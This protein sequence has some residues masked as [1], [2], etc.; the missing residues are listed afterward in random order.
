MIEINHV[1]LFQTNITEIYI[2]PS[3]YD[4]E[5]IVKTIYENYK[6]NSH[7]NNWDDNSDLHQY[8]RDWNNPNFLQINFDSLKKVYN[9]TF[10]S[11]IESISFNQDSIFK[12]RWEIAN[13]TV[14]RQEQYM[15]VHDHLADSCVFSVVHYISFSDSHTLINFKN[16]LLA[17]QYTHP[18]IEDY[19]N[20]LKNDEVQNSTYFKEWDVKPKEDFMLI[21]P[22]YL[23]HEVKRIKHDVEDPKLRIAVVSNI[24][25]M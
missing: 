3:L 24:C 13:V 9:H 18:I 23:K 22:S 20:F 7:R 8:Y 2:D 17:L 1:P 12:F 15:N 25:L 10:Q 14:Y 5:R 6:K 11:F 19:S 4:K 16:P 21:F